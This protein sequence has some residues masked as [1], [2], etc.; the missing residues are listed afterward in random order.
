MPHSQRRFR[1]LKSEM[2]KILLTLQKKKKG[3]KKLIREYYEQIK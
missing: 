3:K 2:E 1:L